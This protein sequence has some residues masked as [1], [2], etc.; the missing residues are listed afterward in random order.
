MEGPEGGI[1]AG[2]EHGSSRDSTSTHLAAI[3][4]ASGFRSFFSTQFGEKRIVI[5]GTREHRVIL[6]HSE[7]LFF[8]AQG[9]GAVLQRDLE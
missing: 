9:G 3:A 2:G 1:E 6:L 8:F 5:H 7:T 4:S